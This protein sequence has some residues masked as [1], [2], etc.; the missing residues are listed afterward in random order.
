[1]KTKDPLA[2]E[3]GEKLTKNLLRLVPPLTHKLGTFK[4]SELGRDFRKI[5]NSYAPTTLSGNLSRNLQIFTEDFIAPP[6]RQPLYGEFLVHSKTFHTQEP[7]G[8]FLF[9][10]NQG[11]GPECTNVDTVFSPVSL[12]RV[13][14]LD[15]AGAQH[16]HRISHI[17]YESES[18]FLNVTANVKELMESGGLHKYLNPVGPLVQN[19]QSTFLNK[20]TTVVRGEVLSN[21]TPP[22]NIKLTLPANLYFDMDD[23]CPYSAAPGPVKPR[24]LYY[25]SLLYVMVNNNPSA[26]L[27]FFRT[28]KGPGDVVLFLRKYYSDA[29][30]NKITVLGDELDINNLTLG[31]VC[32]LGYSS[33]QSNPNRG[34]LHFRTY[35][36]PTVEVSDFVADPGSW[37]L[38]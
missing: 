29:I 12:F 23:T 27:Q 26:Y 18:D 36:L 33:S 24:V 2:G 19:I 17:W 6:Y 8:T 3:T 25:A 38:F 7:L 35:S 14:G 32:Q 9:A 22:E 15:A 30:A 4:G 10:F 28:G 20:L 31:A 13:L 16:T 37:N 11:D 34:N 1:M 5:V 21:R